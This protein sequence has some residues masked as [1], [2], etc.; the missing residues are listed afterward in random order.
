MNISRSDIEFT[1]IRSLAHSGFILSGATIS[2]EDRRERIRI[3]IMKAQVGNKP[4]PIDPSITYAQAY[5]IAYNR[6]CE[7][8][9]SERETFGKMSLLPVEEAA[10]GA[11]EEMD[12]DEVDSGLL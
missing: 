12:E 1:F 2:A 4:L 6:P 7:L 8:R 9:S 5:Q 10:N 3:A 11:E